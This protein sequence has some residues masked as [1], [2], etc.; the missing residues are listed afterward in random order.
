[1]AGIRLFGNGLE[2]FPNIG[3]S[4]RGVRSGERTVADHVVGF[5]RKLGQ[6]AD[7]YRVRDAKMCGKPARQNQTFDIVHASTRPIKQCADSSIDC[8]FG[9]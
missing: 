6:E 7:K 9:F 2:F 4:Q 1:M 3:T 5:E 8:R